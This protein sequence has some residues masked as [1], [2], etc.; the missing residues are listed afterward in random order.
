MRTGSPGDADETPNADG[1]SPRDEDAANDADVRNTVHQQ[2]G[3]TVQAK[4]VGSVHIHGG[5]RQ[6]PHELPPAVREFAGRADEL[7]RLDEVLAQHSDHGSPIV[8]TGPAAAGKTALA[9]HWAGRS[10]FRDGEIFLDLGG[11]GAKTVQPE[12]ALASA[13]RSLGDHAGARAPTLDE[14]SRRYR[15][16][17][18]GQRMLVLLDNVRDVAQARPLLPNDG[19]SLVLLTSRDELDGL[20]GDPARIRLR[21]RPDAVPESPPVTGSPVTGSPVTDLPKADPPAEHRHDV[22]VSYADEDAD[23]V[24]EFVEHLAARGV[25]VA[26]DVLLPGDQRAHTVARA[27]VD[28]KQGLLVFS[29]TAL[30]DGWIREEYATLLQRSVETGQRFIPVVI[31]DVSLPPFASTRSPCIFHGAADKDYERQI[32]R[33]LRALKPDG[34]S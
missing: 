28:S 13:L 23:W 25:A 21:P 2:Q 32:D 29:R 9:V 16:A 34:T 15:S 3:N 17:L 8:I 5:S 18:R 14:L 11:N 27:I 4:E 20:P 26:H 30:D 7:A 6:V 10:D 33:L 19:A 12:D 1:E 24:H 22:F 31:D